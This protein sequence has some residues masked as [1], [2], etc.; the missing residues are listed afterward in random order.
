MVTDDFYF[1]RNINFPDEQLLPMHDRVSFNQQQKDSVKRQLS[2]FTN[3][4]FETAKYLIMNNK[5]E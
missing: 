2:L 3:G 5:K 1:S 4:F